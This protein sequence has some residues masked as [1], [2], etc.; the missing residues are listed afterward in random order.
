MLGDIGAREPLALLLW[1]SV[2]TALKPLFRVC[3]YDEQLVFIHDKIRSVSSL[4]L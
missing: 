4:L 1:K 2:K 3:N